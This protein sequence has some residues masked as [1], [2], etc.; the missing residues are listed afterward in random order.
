[1][2]FAKVDPGKLRKGA[3]ISLDETY[4]AIIKAAQDYYRAET[5]S[6]AVRRI[7]EDWA[8]A[9]PQDTTTTATAQ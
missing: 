9:H 7:L 5:K 1:M 2:A 6:A 3:G 4:L 8:E